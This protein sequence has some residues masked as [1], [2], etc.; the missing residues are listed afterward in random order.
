MGMM[1]TVKLIEKLAEILKEKPERILRDAIKSFVELQ[2]QKIRAE[3]MSL[4]AKYSGYGVRSFRDLMSLVEKGILSDVDIHDD[5][6]RLDYLE[7][8]EKELTEFLRKL[9]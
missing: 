9:Q 2:L 7:S 6:I 4:T 5:L 1:Q 3:K 8:R